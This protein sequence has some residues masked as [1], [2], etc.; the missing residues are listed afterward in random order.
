MSA[1][2]GHRSKGVTGQTVCAHAGFG[3]IR[4][5]QSTGSMV[6]HVTADDIT[7]WLTGTSAPC[8]SVFK[9]VWFDGGLPDGPRPG[10]RFDASTTW[11]RHELLHRETLRNYPERIA[12]FAQDRDDLEREFLA[13]RGHGRGQGRLHR[14]VLRAGRGRRGEVAGRG[15]GHS[16]SP[17][18]PAL[19]RRAWRTWNDQAGMP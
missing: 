2:T 9:P 12:A 16:A 6:A 15:P 4:V 5:A 11:W 3:P 13:A 8:T 1:P 10:R 18:V 14:R 19:Y 7:V 17:A